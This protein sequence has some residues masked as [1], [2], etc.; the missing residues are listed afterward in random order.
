MY[1][2][3]G[4]HPVETGASPQ[5]SPGH[6]HT[7][8]WSIPTLQLVHPHPMQ[9]SIPTLGT[10]MCPPVSPSPI[11]T[12]WHHRIPSTKQTAAAGRAGGRL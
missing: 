11:L 12:L 1:Q 9:Q 4:C 2:A 8:A 5:S 7:T 6:P 10:G 3:A